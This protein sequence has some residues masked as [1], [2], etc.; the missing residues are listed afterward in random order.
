MRRRPGFESRSRYRGPR[1]FAPCWRNTARMA[2]PTA[3]FEYHGPPVFI[4]ALQKEVRSGDQVTGPEALEHSY[5][6]TRVQ[7]APKRS[8]DDD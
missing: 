7:P 6:F 5:G 4:V 2:E 1:G 3:K 8:K